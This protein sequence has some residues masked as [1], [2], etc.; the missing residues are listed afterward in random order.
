VAK[1]V[2]TT[3]DDT[4]CTVLVGGQTPENRTY[5]VMNQNDGKIY[6]LGDFKAS[7]FFTTRYDFLSAEVA[8]INMQNV[9]GYTL[10]KGADKVLQIQKN[11]GQELASLG[12][13]V[14]VYP[15]KAEVGVQDFMSKLSGNFQTVT[16]VSF[17]DMTGKTLAEV[18]LSPAQYTAQID[19]TDGNYIFHFGTVEDGGN[20]YVKMDGREDVFTLESSVLAYIK[21]QSPFGMILKFAHLVM[22][23]DIDSV[24]LAGGGETY[25]LTIERSGGAKTFAIND[26]TLDEETF[27]ELYK[28]MV[29]IEVTGEV[30][31]EA[32]GEMQYTMTFHYADGR[33][34]TYTYAAYDERNLRLVKADGS[35]YFTVLK[36]NVQNVMDQLKQEAQ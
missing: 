15:Y 19:T 29:G 16:A 27:T 11:E 3:T 26:K 25:Q 22:L 36:R 9:T 32:N 24:T 21:G 30:V 4:S 7:Y 33:T 6:V 23:D 14:M 28:A 13:L 10:Q 31:G 5:Y 35:A 1:A 20:V 34:E 2:I 18:G 8:S 12:S 17:P